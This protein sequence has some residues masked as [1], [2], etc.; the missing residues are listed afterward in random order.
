MT[1][2]SPAGA[3]RPLTFPAPATPL[4][5]LKRQVSTTTIS[6]TDD[7]PLRL[8]AEEHPGPKRQ[9]RVSPG[10]AAILSTPPFRNTDSATPNANRLARAQNT[11]RLPLEFIDGFFV[12]S[13]GTK[14]FQPQYP[15]E[16][17]SSP[18][19]LPQRPWKQNVVAREMSEGALNN[20][21]VRRRIDM[22][23]QNVPYKTE[24]PRDAPRLM[25]HSKHSNN[26]THC[27]LS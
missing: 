2:I 5:S 26:D 6:K 17:R 15:V 24:P 16:G 19:S 1:T 12:G 11:Q 7:N 27:D 9:K 13:E 4:R 3:H 20:P 10:S 25:A 23:V 8:P 18:P 14:H 22:Q 21:G